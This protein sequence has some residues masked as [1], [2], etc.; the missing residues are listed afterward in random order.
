MK[1]LK[2]IFGLRCHFLLITHF[3]FWS[4]ISKSQPELVLGDKQYGNDECVQ[5]SSDGLSIYT[6][7]FN[8]IKTWNINT[9]KVE[10]FITNEGLGYYIKFCPNKKIALSENH[11]IVKIWNIESGKLMYSLN[12]IDADFSPDGKWIFTIQEGPIEN[13]IGPL[14][15]EE[16]EEGIS[17][18]ETTTGIL[19]HRWKI[20][21]KYSI[22][23]ASIS[24]DSKYLRVFSYTTLQVWDIVNESMISSLKYE[25]NF[26]CGNVDISPDGE[27]M[28]INGWDTQ[29]FHWGRGISTLWRLSTGSIYNSLIKKILWRQCSAGESPWKS[30]FS[31]DGKHF[32][33]GIDCSKVGIWDS[34]TGR[35][36]YTLNTGDIYYQPKPAIFS[37]DGKWIAT[38]REYWMIES[39]DS[40]K[41]WDMKTGRLV[42]DIKGI[43]AGF[44]P[45]LPVVLVY[46]NSKYSLVSLENGKTILSWM[47]MDSEDWVVIHPSGLFDASPGAMEKLYFIQD[48]EIIELESLKDKYYEPGLWE[49][50]MSGEPLRA[51]ENCILSFF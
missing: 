38:T 33:L 20:K 25:K 34:A 4:A 5:F 14:P 19:I 9:G 22:C 12:G 31:H 49:K 10:T 37:P 2:N 29:S 36:L 43:F 48:D 17:F 35:L 44:H 47:Y 46:D 11:G 15:L 42:W 8:S 26:G 39:R 7:Y 13:Y 18:N 1:L 27:W 51:I 30:S 32:S 21:S 16:Y 23:N 3:L 41:I 45:Y 6:N 28:I 40:T 24:E 50:V